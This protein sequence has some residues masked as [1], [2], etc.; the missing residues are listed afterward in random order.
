MDIGRGADC[1]KDAI[2]M[3]RCLNFQFRSKGDLTEMIDKPLERQW[4]QLAKS[5]FAMGSKS[6]TRVGVTIPPK[7]SVAS[8]KRFIEPTVNMFVGSRNHGHRIA[9]A[10]LHC[11][12]RL[13]ENSYLHDDNYITNRWQWLLENFFTAYIKEKEV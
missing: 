3:N 7:L 9:P 11:F 2:F 4:K 12:L 10:I 13:E 8:I 1:L 5:Y 6:Y